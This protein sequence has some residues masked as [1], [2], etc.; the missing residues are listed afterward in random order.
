MRIKP[1]DTCCVII[2]Y[3]EQILPTMAEKEKLIAN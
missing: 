1:E 2:D 3:Q